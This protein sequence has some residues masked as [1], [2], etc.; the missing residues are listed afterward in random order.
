MSLKFTI[1][2][3][4][5][6]CTY[7]GQTNESFLIRRPSFFLATTGEMMGCNS[8]VLINLY[9]IEKIPVA[10][11]LIIGFFFMAIAGKNSEGEYLVSLEN[12]HSLT[13]LEGQHKNLTFYG[14][15]TI[16]NLL[17]FLKLMFFIWYIIFFFTNLQV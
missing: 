16:N 14:N 12:A 2:M 5:V 6:V 4:P 15:C 10:C 13:F 17:L 9:L 11:L 7:N 3:F 1:K 8:I